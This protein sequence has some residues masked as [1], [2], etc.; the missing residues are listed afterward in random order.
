MKMAWAFAVFVVLAVAG[1]VAY[2]DWPRKL[3]LFIPVY[4]GPVV[5][6]GV[7]T[8]PFPTW[9]LV[10]EVGDFN[11]EL[12]AYLWF[13][14]LRGRKEVDPSRV[15]LT[16]KEK[17]D[18][19][20]YRI[21]MELPNDAISAVSY[22]CGLEQKDYIDHYNFVFSSAER[23]SYMQ[24]QTGIF[25]AAY[26]KPAQ[27]TLEQLSSEQ[28][29]PS[30][31][32]FVLFK[33]RTDGR[34]RA[35]ELLRANNLDHEQA[36]QMAADMIAVAKFYDLPLDVFL[37]IGAMENNYHNSPGDLQNAVW[38]R[39]PAKDDIILGRRRGK[40]LVSNYSIGPW[41]IT[42]E[43]MRYAHNLYLKDKRDY[44][45]LP[46]RLRPP[47]KLSFDLTNSHVLTTYAGLLLRDLLD[48][49]NG[50]VSKAV[51]A[52]NGGVK[53]PNPKYAA[54]V[55]MV[56]SYA[57]NVLERVD[58]P[59][60]PDIEP[61]GTTAGAAPVAEP[62]AQSNGTQQASNDSQTPESTVSHP[63]W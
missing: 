50:D 46:E 43:T 53:N 28:L 48:K 55:E 44:A 33:A 56:A 16:V 26:R 12:S 37:G 61:T 10:A 62:V 51:G 5:H 31:A 32:R 42:R 9:N 49:F 11:D 4:P 14:Y 13:D 34:M 24:K 52:Y 2:R 21:Y 3:W 17:S 60:S 19:P 7:I 59:A 45:Q 35:A 6:Q 58:G 23:L 20:D 18:K 38:K 41:Q 27:N 63:V 1:A 30:V 29:L 15:F 57:R 39:H 47:Q 8:A 25:E 36:T 40:Y 22:L 54:G